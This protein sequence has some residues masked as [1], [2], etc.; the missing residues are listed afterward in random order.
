M[1]GRADYLPIIRMP[2]DEIPEDVP[3]YYHLFTVEFVV[4]VVVCSI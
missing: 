1:V 3:G 4:G 2:E